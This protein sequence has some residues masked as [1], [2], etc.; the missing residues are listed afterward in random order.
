MSAAAAFAPIRRPPQWI[1]DASLNVDVR[2]CIASEILPNL[3][4]GRAEFVTKLV[5]GESN[6]G[7]ITHVLTVANDTPDVRRSVEDYNDAR[8]SDKSP[9]AYK[10]VEIRDFG[11]DPGISRKFDEGFAFIKEG[12]DSGGVVFVHCANGT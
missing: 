2:G 11:T 1:L 8:T 4:L 10:C 7:G 12:L 9:L 3:W 5:V 6:Q